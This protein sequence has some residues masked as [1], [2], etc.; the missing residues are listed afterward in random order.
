MGRTNYI[1]IY[2]QTERDLKRVCARDTSAKALIWEKWGP[3]TV[4][5]V[6]ARAYLASLDKVSL[7]GSGRIFFT[8]ERFADVA[9]LGA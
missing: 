9:F 6:A 4:W 1:L 2:R 8:E 7:I 3:S 5:P